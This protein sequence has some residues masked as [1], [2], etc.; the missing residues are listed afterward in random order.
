[1]SGSISLSAAYKT[2]DGSLRFLQYLTSREL[3]TMDPILHRWEF[4]NVTGKAAAQGDLRTLQWLV[5]SYRPGELLTQAVVEAVGNGHLHI[6]E[7]LWENHRSRV[8]WGGMEL[9]L[10]KESYHHDVVQWLRARTEISPEN[11]QG[12]LLL[13]AENGD[14]EL[15]RVLYETFS[16]EINAAVYFAA[17][18]CQ[19][20]VVFWFADNCKWVN[21]YN[22][23]DRAVKLGDLDTL[24][25]L[26]DRGLVLNTEDILEFAAKC[27]QL[28]IVKWLY[29][30]KGLTKA[31]HGYIAAVNNGRIDVLEYLTDKMEIMSE[32]DVDNYVMDEAVSL[33]TIQWLHF[34][35]NTRCSY[36][37]MNKAAARGDLEM[38]Q[39]LHANRSEG[40]S[41][42]A[43]DRAAINGHLDMRSV[44]I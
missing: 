1:M 4:N 11:A 5:E 7:W 19:W 40:C 32:V 31:G 41:S 27:G 12:L 23:H 33:K 20:E 6:L 35:A 30:V 17:A 10:V 29:E 16:V 15:V 2:S 39:W 22:L 38:V 8:V 26:F 28:H 3:P 21:G 9:C 13:A 34:H 43:M 25:V 42:S 14:M 18:Y 37:A 44:A 24:K 36:R